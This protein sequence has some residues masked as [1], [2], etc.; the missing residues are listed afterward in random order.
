MRWLFVLS[1]AACTSETTVAP[2]TIVRVDVSG[3]CD[4]GDCS[5]YSELTPFCGH[6]VAYIDST[7]QHVDAYA[8]GELTGIV[9]LQYIGAAVEGARTTEPPHIDYTLANEDAVEVIALFAVQPDYAALLL[10]RIDASGNVTDINTDVLESATDR[11]LR[12]TYAPSAIKNG[13]PERPLVTEQ[14][15]INPPRDITV[16]VQDPGDCCSVG[17]PSGLALIGLV[18]LFVRRRRATSSA[19]FRPALE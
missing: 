18:L 15:T 10:Y 1:L 13:F 5:T 12:F 11:T 6:D 14:H 8:S 2:A 4:S 7:T 17:R 3:A 19:R 9:Q 16:N